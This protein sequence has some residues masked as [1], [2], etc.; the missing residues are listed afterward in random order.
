VPPPQCPARRRWAAG[1]A[2]WAAA[3]CT[4]VSDTERFEPNPDLVRIEQ[5]VPAAGARDVAPDAQLAFCLS[6]WLDPR[7][8]AEMDAT[9]ASGPLVFDSELAVELVPWHDP[10]GAPARGADAPWCDGSVLT[11][12][13]KAELSLGVRYRVLLEA[14]LVGWD[15]EALDLDQPGWIDDEGNPRFV[16]EFT[17]TDT[18]PPAMPEPEPVPAPVTLAN[19]FADDGPLDPARGQCSCHTEAGADA[20][21][22]ARLDLSDPTRAYQ[23]LLGSSRIRDTGFPMISPRDPSGSFFVHKLLREASGDALAGVLGDPMPPD[24]PLAYADLRRI[25]QWIDDGARP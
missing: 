5:T 9:I 13:P 22:I 18:E 16:V 12:E 14:T 11:I 1:L 8:V 2:L 7:S 17:V 10:G 23:A 15:G 21:A 24:D 20:L 19:L 3:S 6:R 25:M 4:R